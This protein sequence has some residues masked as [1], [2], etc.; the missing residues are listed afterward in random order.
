MYYVLQN[1]E[2]AADTS[3]NIQW[4][5]VFPLGQAACYTAVI[6][7]NVVDTSVNESIIATKI[8]F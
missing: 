2:A 5:T 6:G 3:S 7:G 1:S 8:C 4:L